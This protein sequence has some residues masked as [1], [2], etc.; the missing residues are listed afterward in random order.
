MLSTSQF[1]TSSRRLISHPRN[2]WAE[3]FP[4]FREWV[5]FHHAPFLRPPFI[6]GW[7][8][9]RKQNNGTCH[10]LGRS[11]P[12]IF[13]DRFRQPPGDA[14]KRRREEPGSADR[15]RDYDAQLDRVNR[16]LDP[17]HRAKPVIDAPKVAA[18]GP[19]GHAE[20]GANLLITLTVNQ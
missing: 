13:R 8:R 1:W 19:L 17:A 16:G 10:S 12:A 5:Q 6:P 4:L 9:P 2:F 3:L 14:T 15:R 11:H 18:N 7:R 20:G